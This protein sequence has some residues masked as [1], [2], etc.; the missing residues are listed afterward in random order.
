M[1]SF[2]IIICFYNAENKL[3]NTLEHIKKIDTSQVGDVELIL[4]NNNS[5]DNSIQI[6]NQEMIGFNRFPWIVVEEK[7]PGLANARMKGFDT[8]QHDFL[9]FCDDDNWLAEDYLTIGLLPLLNDNKIAVVGGC[10]TA[11]SDVDIP[12]WFEENQNYFA[13]GPQWDETGEVKVKRNMVYG[14]GMIVRKSAFMFLINNGFKFFAL[15]RTGKSLSSGEDSEMCLAFRIGG[16]K[17]WYQS[18]LKFK[19]YIEPKRL[20]QEYFVALVKGMSSSN[21]VSKF[22]RDYLFGYRP[23]ISKFFWLKET[24]YLQF[25]II[26]KIFKFNFVLKFEFEYLMYLIKQRSSYDKNVGQIID[27]CNRIESKI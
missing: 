13:V 10:G 21:Y 14:A 11:V 23:K 1:N 7:N 25:E 2:S 9:L 8:S 6:I 27:F 3:K 12:H 17:I 26:K 4:V 5:N 19:H 22:Y 20:T 18:N 16:F 24:L 15:G